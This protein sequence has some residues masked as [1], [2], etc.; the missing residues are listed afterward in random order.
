MSRDNGQ[1]I[2][3]MTFISGLQAMPLGLAQES[4]RQHVVASTATAANK[5]KAE[6]AIQTARSTNALMLAL[7]NFSLSHQGM[8][9]IR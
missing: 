3:S 9:V 7:S 4:A 6:K 5:A 8:K 1:G 2:F